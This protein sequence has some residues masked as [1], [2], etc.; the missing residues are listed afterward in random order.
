MGLWSNFADCNLA[1]RMI[2]KGENF[3]EAFVNRFKAAGEKISEAAN[4]LADYSPI[5][6][7]IKNDEGLFEA[8][9][10]A[11]GEQL[12]FVA[13]RSVIGRMIKNDENYG[14][15]WVNTGKQTLED[16]KNIIV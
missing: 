14:E 9:K 3:G 7:M 10:N 8:H 15:A 16:I 2:T 13:D 5:G 4:T 12:E 1:G 6:R 11:Y